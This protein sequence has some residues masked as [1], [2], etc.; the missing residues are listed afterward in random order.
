M[1]RVIPRPARLGA[2]RKWE[3][4]E[5]VQVRAPIVVT[6]DGRVFGPTARTVWERLI[7]LSSG[8][9][10]QGADLSG[11]AAVE[12]FEASRQAAESQGSTIF[13]EL[14]ASH[15]L[16]I[17]RERKKGAHAF[18]SRRRAIERLGLPHVRAHRLRLMADEEQVWSRELAA[19]EAAL[20]DLA[21]ILMVCVAS[22]AKA[23]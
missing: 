13:D 14:A 9:S 15:Q 10:Q 1:A 11:K 19:R 20:P 7:D 18:A 21:P 8:L 4:V 17:A 2:P 12:A 16:S 5:P 6:E 22:I 3:S 23:A